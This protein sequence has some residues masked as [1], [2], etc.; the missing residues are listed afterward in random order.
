[1]SRHDLWVLWG[2]L[3]G[4]FKSQLCQLLVEQPQGQSTQ[5]SCWA[6]A[7][8]TKGDV[9][10]NSVYGKCRDGQGQTPLLDAR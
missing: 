9:L 4:G 1:M 3:V 7:A 10:C 8:D 5:T 6:K 2:E